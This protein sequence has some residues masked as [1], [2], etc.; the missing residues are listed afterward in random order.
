MWGTPVARDDQK[1]PEAHLA[2]KARMGGGRTEATS[3]TVQAKMWPAPRASMNENRT[4]R[5]A[6]SHGTTH[7]LTLAGE[8][9]RHDRTTGTDG[10]NGSPKADLNPRF[11]AAL[12]GLPWDWLT[13]ST[14][15]ETDSS[16]SAPPKH[17]D[18]SATG[19][20]HDS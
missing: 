9:S 10:N 8:A 18:N 16:P 17:S 7:G 13:L 2:M 3:L 19:S 5:N 1:S 4:S 20:T 6:R 11:V 14:S 15:A 12:M